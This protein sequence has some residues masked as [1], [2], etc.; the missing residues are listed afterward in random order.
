M[1]G[2]SKYSEYFYFLFC[3]EDLTKISIFPININNNA[4]N[5]Y[6]LFSNL[7]HI[8]TIINATAI[9]NKL[10]VQIVNIF[11]F[12]ILLPPFIQL[13]ILNFFN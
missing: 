13:F 8:V 4:N 7:V 1:F 2:I 9:I 10:I 3:N 12:F 5:K 6:N 11:S